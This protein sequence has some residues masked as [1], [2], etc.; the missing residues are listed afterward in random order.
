MLISVEI[1][2][3]FIYKFKRLF[4]VLAFRAVQVLFHWQDILHKVVFGRA[5]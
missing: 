4:E 2:N 1:F 3:R 5:F